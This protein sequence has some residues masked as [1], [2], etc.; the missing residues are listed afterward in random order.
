MRVRLSAGWLPPAPGSQ[1]SRPHFKFF[2]TRKEQFNKRVRPLC[3][4]QHAKIF[5]CAALPSLSRTK[6]QSG[7]NFARTKILPK[8]N[9]YFKGRILVS[10]TLFCCIILYNNEGVNI[11]S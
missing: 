6:L 7:Q 8:E 1:P 5:L 2:T 3:R 11:L 4:S 9:R 10:N